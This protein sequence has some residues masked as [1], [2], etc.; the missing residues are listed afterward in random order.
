LKEELEKKKYK[1]DIPD[2]P[3]FRKDLPD[4]KTVVNQITFN[5]KPEKNTTI[6]GHSLGC[7]L[8]L[9]L[10][11]RM[12]FEKLILVAGWDF[13]DLTQGHQSF[14][15]NKLDHEKI[16]KNVNEIYIIH[17]DNDPYITAS[18]A[19]DMSKRLDGKFILVK[20][21]GHFTK[22]NNIT[23]LPQALEIIN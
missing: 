14:W 12:E 19:E 13:D 15:R 10:A 21:A 8:A 11:E 6:I 18:Q 16:K 3:E 7:L 22:N 17:S 23:E 2:M 5:N 4:M 1:V 20:G 9:R